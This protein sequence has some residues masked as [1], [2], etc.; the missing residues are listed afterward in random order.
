MKLG[1]IDK[2]KQYNFIIEIIIM[3]K[4]RVFELIRS[5]KVILWA[6]A[7]LSRY[8]GYPTGAG[9]ANLLIEKTIES[10][11]TNY[12]SE[13]LQDVA[14]EFIRIH[15]GSRHVLTEVLQKEFLQKKPISVE[16]HEK[17]ASI[18]HINT[19]VTT[20]Y[21]LLFENAYPDIKVIT[22][23]NE[24]TY[25]KSNN[26]ILYKIHGSLNASD[27][28]I[29]REDYAKF[30]KNDKSIINAHLTSHISTKNILFLGYGYEDSN[31]SIL[32]DHVLS[33]VGDDY[34][35]LFLVAP[36]LSNT[37]QK[38]LTGKRITYINSTGEDF[39]D[40]LIENI[41]SNI[42]KDLDKGVVGVD[43]VNKFL[44]KHHITP[45]FEI[46]GNTTPKITSLTGIDG[47][48][49]EGEMTISMVEEKMQMLFD[50]ITGKEF[51]DF[52]ISNEDLKAFKVSI[53]GI[54]VLDTENLASIVISPKPTILNVDI[55]IAGFEINNVSLKIFMSEHAFESRFELK[56]GI[57]TIKFPIG[58][59]YKTQESF[60]GRIQFE[61][62]A[63]ENIKISDELDLYKFVNYIS[64][65]NTITI[66]FENGKS[67]TL[68]A[69]NVDSLYKETIGYLNIL[70]RL[71][72]IESYFNIRFGYIDN[73]TPE[74][75]KKINLAN[76][77]TKEE[78]F[79][80]S[81]DAPLTLDIHVDERTENII[82]SITDPIKVKYN[83]IEEIEIFGITI[84][85]GYR[86]IIFCDPYVVN[87]RKL[88]VGEVFKAQ[89]L[90]RTNKALIKYYK[91]YPEHIDFA[92]M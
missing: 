32:F 52:K 89:I 86:T 7:G 82:T 63:K 72:N 75:I 51:S 33:I 91:E 50:H 58:K 43:T 12:N 25:I 56:R 49:L 22:K 5:E 3:S 57:I 29:T 78:E 10:E 31:I 46:L 9:L 47:N 48:D 34:H 44:Q 69:G 14:E 35:E 73:L 27:Y 26:P 61:A 8:A 88:E 74:I 15:N 67:T 87:M 84:P 20:N 90:G 65:G 39:I 38:H 11:R 41:K 42:T 16:Y 30:I 62:H 23:D 55:T 70:E 83:Y 13:T 2:E 85:L 17:L 36:N 1:N 40:E 80:G 60:D 64:R 6:G 19:I 45:A 54:N 76:A 21:D 71:R 18:P 59:D 92:I 79:T 53:K 77:V 66:H 28:V 4:E 68:R 24:A 81:W 37:K